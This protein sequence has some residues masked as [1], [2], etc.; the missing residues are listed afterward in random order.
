MHLF[1]SPVLFRLCSCSQWISALYFS[2]LDFCRYS[3]FLNCWIKFEFF[4]LLS[5]HLFCV[6]LPVV[7]VIKVW[8]I[9]PTHLHSGVCFSEWNH[10]R[11][12]PVSQGYALNFKLRFE[13]CYPNTDFQINNMKPRTGQ[14]INDLSNRKATSHSSHSSSYLERNDYCISG[15]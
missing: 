7:W 12:I 14:Y 8:F 5:C 15:L 9:P 6:S 13:R 11:F 3:F 4:F 10:D 2:L 1:D